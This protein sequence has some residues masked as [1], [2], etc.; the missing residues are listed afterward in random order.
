[1]R[2]LSDQ[3][4]PLVGGRLDYLD[5][6]PAA[7]LVY[8]FRQH[9]IEVFVQPAGGAVAM[10]PQSD[11]GYHIVGWTADGLTLRAVSDAD[12]TELKRLADLL[13]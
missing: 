9:V 6:R 8:R 11:D 7:V 5:R 2:D 13:R 4:F 3:G 1:V 12:A 10:A